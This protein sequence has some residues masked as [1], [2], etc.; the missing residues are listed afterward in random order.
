MITGPS[1]LTLMAFNSH[2]RYIASLVVSDKASN[3][4]SVLDVV[5][6]ACFLSFH[7]T[8]PPNSVIIYP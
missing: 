8:G 1:S 2:L 3:S 5:T 7:A 6:V 4:A